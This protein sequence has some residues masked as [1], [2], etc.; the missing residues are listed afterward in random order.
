MIYLSQD[1]E[2]SMETLRKASLEPSLSKSK[3]MG[4][5]TLLPSY[6]LMHH[7]SGLGALKPDLTNLSTTEECQPPPRHSAAPPCLEAAP[8]L[9]MLSQ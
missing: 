9:E 2:Y 6:V 3:E 7:G 8:H 1:P 5:T 4:F